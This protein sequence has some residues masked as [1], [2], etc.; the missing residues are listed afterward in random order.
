MHAYL[1][2]IKPEDIL[3]LLVLIG[4]LTLVNQQIARPDGAAYRYARRLAVGVF[5]LYAI[6]SLFVF[7]IEGPGD[8]VMILIRS[9]LAAGVV[10]GFA[11]LALAVL[12]NLIGDPVNAV[13]QR[14]RSWRVGV[15]SRKLQADRQRQE[16]EMRRRERIEQAR[17]LPLLEQENQQKAQAAART[18]TERTNR[19][20]DAR[21]AVTQLYDENADLL[22]D[23]L[24]PLLFKSHLE[25]RF[26]PS[27]QPDQAWQV[28]NALMAEIQPQILAAK[29]KLRTTEQKTQERSGEIVRR[30]R[31]IRRLEEEITKITEAP[32][33]DRDISEPEIRTIRE[34]IRELQD[35]IES[36]ESA[37]EGG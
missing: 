17:R 13:Q 16:E 8:L 36:L 26:P 24:P 14:Y 1:D 9:G 10:F 11:T 33:F 22:K 30:Q 23:I 6:V 21:S 15:R 19:V 28:A 31:A 5:A 29:D 34:Q 2:W 12:T 35:E 3:P 20:A 32:G 7:T 37:V 25:T 4:L 27:I 18:Q